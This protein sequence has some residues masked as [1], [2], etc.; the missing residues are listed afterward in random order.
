MGFMGPGTFAGASFLFSEKFGDILSE[1]L[2]APAVISDSEDPAPPLFVA[3]RVICEKQGPPGSRKVYPA[4]R[5]DGGFD[6][7]VVGRHIGYREGD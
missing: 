1:Y 5:T 7:E 3:L 2:A 4:V 6:V